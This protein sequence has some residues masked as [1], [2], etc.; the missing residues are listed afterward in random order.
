MAIVILPAQG[1]H[2]PQ[3]SLDRACAALLA[4][5]VIAVP[6]DTLYGLA[7]CAGV[8]GTTDRIFAVK[9]RPKDVALPLL[10][11]S[12]ADALELC[13]PQPDEVR[14]LMA[15][16]WPGALTIVVRRR[17]GL[18]LDL[19]GDGTTI[20]LRCPDDAI[21]R[22][23]AAR[24][25]PLAIT[26]ANRHGAPTPDTALGVAQELGRE[27]ALVLDG[28][29]R[30]GEPS[31]VVDVTGPEPRLLRAGRIPWPDI[32]ATLDSK[33]SGGGSAG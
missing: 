7:A 6:T 27:I 14:A 22:P 32:L 23:L 26:S 33:A 4:G 2:P 8:A 19:G 15:R 18:D 11:G 17:E 5:D 3:L 16:C 20:G 28:G 1:A 10:V 13:A 21:T 12:I 29:V 30:S 25:G 9:R 24:V 31:T